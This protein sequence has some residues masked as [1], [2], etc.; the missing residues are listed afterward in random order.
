VRTGTSACRGVILPGRRFPA[1]RLAHTTYRHKYFSPRR[2]SKPRN[3]PSPTATANGETPLLR[4][5]SLRQRSNRNGGIETARDRSRAARAKERARS[6]GSLAQRA[7][8]FW[9]LDV[10][11]CREPSLSP[12]P[13]AGGCTRRGDHTRV[14][15]ARP[16]AA[17]FITTAAGARAAQ[18]CAG[19]AAA[20]SRNRDTADQISFYYT[21]AERV[22]ARR[23]VYQQRAPFPSHFRPLDSPFL[24]LSFSVS[25]GLSRFLPRALSVRLTLSRFT[26]PRRAGNNIVLAGSNGGNVWPTFRAKGGAKPAQRTPRVKQAEPLCHAV[27]TEH[28]FCFL[29]SATSSFS[30]VSRDYRLR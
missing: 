10:P 29:S 3:L 9:W 16:R 27:F 14:H 25:A 15:A 6:L 11:R 22:R 21:C 18:L 12:L 7:E 4:L 1:R 30:P 24:T 19:A 13:L 23:V 20:R 2:V 5:S 26:A 8:R 17:L 28:L